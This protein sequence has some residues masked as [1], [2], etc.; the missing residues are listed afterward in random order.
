MSFCCSGVHPGRT[1]SSV[2]LSTWFPLSWIAF[3]PSL[4]LMS[5]AILRMISQ[6]F[7]EDLPLGPDFFLLIGLCSWVS[8]RRPTEVQQFSWDGVRACSPGEFLF[9]WASLTCPRKCCRASFPRVPGSLP[10]VLL[11]RSCHV[12]PHLCGGDHV[13]IV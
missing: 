10:S 2:V 3:R 12:Q 5:R 8:R 6:V 4:F 11:R 9:M 1:S 13:P 7:G